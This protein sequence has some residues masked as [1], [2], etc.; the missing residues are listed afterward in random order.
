MSSGLQSG[1]KSE[2]GTFMTYED[3]KFMYRPLAKESYDLARE[4]LFA[5]VFNLNE[6]EG[7]GFILAGLELTTQSE[8]LYIGNEPETQDIKDYDGY[9]MKW[10]I[11]DLEIVIAA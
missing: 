11:K 3:N 9:K 7:A 5:K 6:N 4:P 1:D 10:K 2:L 8:C